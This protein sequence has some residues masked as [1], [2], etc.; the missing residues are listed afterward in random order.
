MRDQIKETN[1]FVKKQSLTS[2]R[3]T[4]SSISH[5]PEDKN[6]MVTNKA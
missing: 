3:D 5:Y 2:C 6:K 1:T 4:S